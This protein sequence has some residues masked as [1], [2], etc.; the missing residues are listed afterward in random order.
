MFIREAELFRGL[1]DDS[2]SEISKLMLEVSCPKGEVLY[3]EADRAENFFLLWEGRIRLA[4]GTEAQI[5][6][7]VSRRGEVFGWSSL[8]DRPNYTARAECMEPSKVYKISKTSIL[9]YFAKNP[10]P[11]MKFFRA[12]AA[13]ALQRLVDNY[14][15]FLSE[16]SLKGVTFSGGTGQ[17]A[18]AGDD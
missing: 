10:A 7:T 16:G 11:G 1:D 18:V 9:D 15:T 17:V 5:D 14:N 3:T 4:I 2:M 13:A 12:L 8:V 6:Y